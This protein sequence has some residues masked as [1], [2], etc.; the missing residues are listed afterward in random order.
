MVAYK[1]DSRKLPLAN[2]SFRHLD[3]ARKDRNALTAQKDAE[4]GRYRWI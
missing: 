2:A 3:S 1:S 4:R